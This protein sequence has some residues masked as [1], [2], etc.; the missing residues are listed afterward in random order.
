MPPDPIQ[1][2]PAQWAIVE[3]AEQDL[4]DARVADLAAIGKPELI[5]TIERL[6]ARLDDT[7]TLIHTI[8]R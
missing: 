5:L 4:T 2:S 1:L 7:L 6:R 8:T 3:F